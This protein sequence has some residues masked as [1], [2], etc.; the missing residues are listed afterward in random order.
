MWTIADN[1][2]GSQADNIHLT[3]ARGVTI[4][5][6]YIYSGH[7]RNL[8][9]ENCRDI[10]LGAN[11]FGHNP[12]YGSNELCTGIRIVDTVNCTISG[13]LI[14]DSQAGQHT[15]PGVEPIVREALIELIRCRRMNIS[16]TEVLDGAP[17]GIYLEECS[18]TIIT[19]CTVLDTREPK[20]TRASIRWK[21]V[22]SGNMIG[23]CR[24]GSGS[25]GPVVAE[26]QVK[27]IDNVLDE[28]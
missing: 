19:G 26:K 22:G 15:V 28:S 6:N 13:M 25:E 11:C 24:L 20:L 27:L 18:D 9:L 16:G 4:T 12:D 10:V 7:H 23:M 14:Q 3:S 2:I 5:G 1:L 21:G 17:Y 8:L